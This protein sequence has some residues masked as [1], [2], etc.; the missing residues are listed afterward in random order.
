MNSPSYTEIKQK[1]HWPATYN[2]TEECLSIYGGDQYCLI[3]D[4]RMEPT[5]LLLGDSH[6]NHFLFWL[7]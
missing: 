1:L 5:H 3:S 7:K 6:A 2:K 4:L